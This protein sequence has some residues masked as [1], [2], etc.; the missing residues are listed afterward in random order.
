MLGYSLWRYQFLDFRE[1]TPFCSVQ[2]ALAFGWG[3]RESS[4]KL[5]DSEFGDLG[6]IDGWHDD[7]VRRVAALGG[8]FV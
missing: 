2:F 1:Y 3:L 8:D 5:S 7:G 4:P 6:A